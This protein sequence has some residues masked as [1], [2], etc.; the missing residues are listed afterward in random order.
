MSDLVTAAVWPDQLKCANPGTV[1]PRAR[2]AQKVGAFLFPG[3]L[4]PDPWQLFVEPLVLVFFLTPG[5]FAFDPS[6]FYGPPAELYPGCLNYFFFH[7]DYG[8][9]RKE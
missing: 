8:A 9:S 2:V 3:F 1:C 5:S 7:A 6:V 4:T